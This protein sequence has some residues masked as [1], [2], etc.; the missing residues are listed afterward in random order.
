MCTQVQTQGTVTPN[1]FLTQRG[2]STVNCGKIS[3]TL[4]KTDLTTVWRTD[5]KETRGEAGKPGRAVA[6]IQ[7]RDRGELDASECAKSEDRGS[8]WKPTGQAGRLGIKGRCLD[9]GHAGLTGL[10]HLLKCGDLGK[11]RTSKKRVC[12]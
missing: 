2:P 6:T 12:F 7:A 10:C 4:Y 5:W 8:G 1:I 11:N 3:L 9:L